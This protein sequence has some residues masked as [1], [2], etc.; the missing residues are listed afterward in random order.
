MRIVLQI[1]GLCFLALA[2]SA[3]NN[4]ETKQLNEFAAKVFRTW[5]TASEE[6]ARR[7][8]KAEM[9][10][11]PEMPNIPDMPDVLPENIGEAIE[12]RTDA[13]VEKA[14]EST[15]T[16]VTKEVTEQVGS[17]IE[18]V[19]ETVEAVTVSAKETVQKAKRRGIY[20][21]G[22]FPRNQ[23]EANELAVKKGR[24]WMD[25]FNDWIKEIGANG[26]IFGRRSGG[27]ATSSRSRSPKDRLKG[28]N[29]L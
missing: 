23:Q 12:E 10:K 13:L 5:D 26:G 25:R 8:E 9:P 19:G 11:L 27:S 22:K 3:C 24:D 7:Y 2:I 6:A 17:E 14:A 28:R 15:A 20:Y 4:R 18:D 16:K 29:R 1:I 21:V